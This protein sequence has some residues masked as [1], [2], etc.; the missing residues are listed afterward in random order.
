MIVKVNDLD[1]T[2]KKP[3]RDV[4]FNKLVTV[5]RTLPFADERDKIKAAIDKN[6]I[7]KC[8]DIIKDYYKVFAEHEEIDVEITPD[9]YVDIYLYSI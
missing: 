1:M 9:E 7:N 3:L 6:T 5:Y 4:I 2:V 8:E